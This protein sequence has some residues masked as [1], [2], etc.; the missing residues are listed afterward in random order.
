MQD[1]ISRR[2]SLG[3]MAIVVLL[4]IQCIIGLLFSI[5]LLVELLAP[6]RP[7]IVQG[8]AIYAGPAAGS[9][10]VIAIASPI[11]AWGMWMQKRWASQRTV[12]LEFISLGISV[13]ELTQP[14]VNRWIT[15]TL[16]IIAVLILICLYADRRVRTRSH[17]G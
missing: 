1:T 4:I 2:N 6:G 9:A 3:I 12:L 17:T 7:V 10:L 5:P 13:L 8:A 16:M 11:I 15:L 14:A